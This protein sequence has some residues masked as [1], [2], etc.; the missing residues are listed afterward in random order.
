MPLKEQFDAA[1]KY[2]A[3]VLHELGHWTGHKDR[4]D[5][6]ILNT[7]GS[8]GYA[9]EELCAEIASLLIGQ[10]FKIGHDPE[11]HAAYVNSWI[12]L[13]QDNPF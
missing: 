12:K 8:E 5:R 1:D 13:L 4:L 2:Y 7:F 10:E 6:S 11:Q 3:T 9:R